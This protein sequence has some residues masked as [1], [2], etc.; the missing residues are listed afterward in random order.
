VLRH[1]GLQVRAEVVVHRRHVGNAVED[2]LRVLA[3]VNSVSGV[4]RS[5]EKNGHRVIARSKELPNMPMIASPQVTEA[6]FAAVRNAM[7]AL[8]SSDTGR[9]ALKKIGLSGFQEA[10]AKDFLEFLK[11]IGDLEMNH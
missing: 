1:A 2:E 6:Q 8:A 7:V 3:V 4:G 11:W 9:A 5:W 10:P